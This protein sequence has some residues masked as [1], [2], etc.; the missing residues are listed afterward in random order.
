MDYKDSLL[1]PNT[2]FSMRGNLVQ[3]EPLKYKLWDEQKVYNKMKSNRKDAISF[4]LHDGP[5]YANG[6]IHIGHALNKILK[7]IVV[8]YHYFQGKSVRFVPGWDCHGLPI[9]QKVEEKLGSTKK[10]E[11]SKTKLR[12]LCRD[13]ATK[14]VDIQ[15]DEF[16]QLLKKANFMT[17]PHHSEEAC[18]SGRFTRI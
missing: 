6:H 18:H 17:R 15:K 11:L 16:K 13:H 3:N 12:Q 2:T 8:K 4:N 14:F 10:K 5:P 9:E 1:L 7:D